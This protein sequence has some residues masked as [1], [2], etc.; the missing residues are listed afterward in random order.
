MRY[1]PIMGM[2]LGAQAKVDTKIQV[3]DP[4]NLSLDLM[5][6][7]WDPRPPQKSYKGNIWHMSDMQCLFQVLSH[8]GWYS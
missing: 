1:D 8:H 5:V 2:L 6:H 4:S 7:T 3:I